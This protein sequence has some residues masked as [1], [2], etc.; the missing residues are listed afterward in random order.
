MKYF[1]PTQYIIASDELM[2]LVIGIA[3]G[4][5]TMAIIDFVIDRGKK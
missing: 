5:V 1:T 3:I 2:W 4:L